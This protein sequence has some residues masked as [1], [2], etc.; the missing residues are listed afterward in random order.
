MVVD[1]VMFSTLVIFL[2][3]IVGLV[4]GGL[5]LF[6]FLDLR[7]KR[8]FIEYLNRKISNQEGKDR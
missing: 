7:R 5:G 1:S 4:G 8:Y 6:V 3:C 2:S